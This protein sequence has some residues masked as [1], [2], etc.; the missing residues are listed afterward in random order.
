VKLLLDQ[1]IQLYELVRPKKNLETI[2]MNLA[3]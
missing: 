2:F 3:K 1:D